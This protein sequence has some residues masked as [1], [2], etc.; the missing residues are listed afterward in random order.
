MSSSANA[1]NA[2]HSDRRTS[3]TLGAKPRVPSSRTEAKVRP[4]SSDD[5][6]PQDSASNAG[7]KRPTSGSFRPN[8]SSIHNINE[9][10]TERHQV[11][12]R[13]NIRVSL[14][15]PLK[16]SMSDK[17]NI[18]SPQ[19]REPLAFSANT[20]ELKKKKTLRKL[21]ASCSM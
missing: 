2:S 8:G 7:N 11:T 13:D 21:Q 4:G 12:T 9:R 14:K 10:Q 18:A 19:H 3:A 1:R 20:A 17:E 5:V 16:P 15:S 6:L